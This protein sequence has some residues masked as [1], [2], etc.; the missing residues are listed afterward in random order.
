VD[1]HDV[2]SNKTVASS[3]VNDDAVDGYI[4][5]QMFIRCAH[6][7]CEKGKSNGSCS[8]DTYSPNLKID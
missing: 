8:T 3:N 2:E 5:A 4:S 1:W 6:H 7:W